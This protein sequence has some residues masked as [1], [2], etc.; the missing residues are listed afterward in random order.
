MTKVKGKDRKRPRKGATNGQKQTKERLTTKQLAL[1]EYKL[2]PENRHKSVSQTCQEL[3]I[4]RQTYYEA[5]ERPLFLKRYQELAVSLT[6]QAVGPVVNAAI[7]EA[8]RGSLGHQEL[9]LQ[10]AGVIPG[11]GKGVEVTTNGD[12]SVKVKVDLL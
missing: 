9:V 11:K 12:G 5:M 6:K 3:G 4:A 2:N 10:M 7:K 8:V 1:L